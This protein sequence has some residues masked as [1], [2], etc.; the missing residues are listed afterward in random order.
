MLSERITTALLHSPDPM[1]EQVVTSILQ[2]DFPDGSL[3]RKDFLEQ[4]TLMLDMGF[5]ITT[6]LIMRIYQVVAISWQQPIAF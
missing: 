5:D 2:D 6:D 1:T 3:E 4:I